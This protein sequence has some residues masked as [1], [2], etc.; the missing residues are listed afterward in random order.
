[1]VDVDPSDAPPN[2]LINSNAS[3]KVKTME[4]EK[5]GAHSITCNIFG[6]RRMCW[7]FRMGIRTN[8]KCVNYSYQFLETKQQVG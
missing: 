3:P 2:S 5:V 8:D 1:M 4:E 6:V 7:S